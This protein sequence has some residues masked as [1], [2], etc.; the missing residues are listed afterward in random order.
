M[1]R[2]LVLASLLTV[3]PATGCRTEGQ[4]AAVE[5]TVPAGSP[6]VAVVDSLS[7][8]GLVD[9]PLLFRVYARVRGAESQ[10]RSGRYAFRTGDGWARILDD[11]VAGRVMTVAMTIPEGFTLRQIAPRVAALSEASE[12]S[13]QQAFRAADVESVYE[14]PGPGLEGYLFPDTYRFAAGTPVRAVLDAMTDRY[15]A[16]WT[17]ERRARLAALEMSERELVTLAS[18]VQA[19]ARRPDEMPSIASVYH[20]RLER[21]WRLEADP[22]VLY[23]LGGPRARLLYAAIDS[24]ADHPYNTYRQA[25]L[26]PGPIGAPGEAALDAALHP[27]QEPYLFFVA[28][29]DGYHTFTRTL[30]EHNR[31]KAEAQRA[32]RER[33]PS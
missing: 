13:V 6:F 10:V 2:R 20:N 28:R 26:P 12:D 15:R 19:E 4:G 25:G 14:V 33:R 22:T 8:R 30:S 24:V 16:F 31:A 21:G 11:M 7:A 3:L 5:V 27:A 23:A 18:I 32:F 9:Q 17:P 29:P 1:K